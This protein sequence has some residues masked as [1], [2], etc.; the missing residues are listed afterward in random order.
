MAYAVQQNNVFVPG[1]L[2][3]GVVPNG[4]VGVL[5]P[6]YTPAFRVGGNYALDC[7]SSIAVSYAQFDSNSASTLSAVPGGVSNI[8]QSLVL[9]PTTVNAGNAA[10]GAQAATY[11]ISFKTANIDY[12]RLLMGSDCF[13]VNYTVGVAYGHLQQGFQETSSFA[14][15]A[16]VIQNTTSIH[17]DGGGLRY[18]L[19]FQRKIGDRG[20]SLYGKTFVDVLFG[21][22][23]AN[24]LQA[25]T[26]TTAVQ[27]LSTWRDDRVLPMLELELGGAWTSCNGRFKVSA[28]Y[29][30]SFW[31][32]AIT[33]SQYVQ[34]VQSSNYTG[35]GQTIAF[36]GLV[37]RAELRF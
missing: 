8:A 21:Q 15:P 10:A 18:G 24:Y 11:N 32:N 37:T 16:G 20:F 34:A 1:L 36:D 13:A 14:P 33:T 26:T 12:R 6:D 9:Q 30:N 4:A 29:Y 31:F 3:T 25:N 19:D 27:A 35:L 22:F 2:N 5:H 23:T 17:Y 7:Y 28:G